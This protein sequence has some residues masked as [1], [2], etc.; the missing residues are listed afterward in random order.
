MA[1]GGATSAT[2][3]ALIALHAAAF[4]LCSCGGGRA[5]RVDR[6]DSAG[7]AIVMNRGPDRPLRWVF[8]RVLVLGGEDEG[9]EAF[10][11]LQR[12][13]VAAGPG[14]EIYVLDVLA[15]RVAAFDSLGGLLWLA[16]RKGGG[17]GEFQAPMSIA[18]SPA[19]EIEVLDLATSLLT[20]LGPEGAYLGSEH[21]A[22]PPYRSR[23]A[24]TAG[25]L[26][27]TIP[28]HDGMLVYVRD[29]DTAELARAPENDAKMVTFRKCGIALRLGRLFSPEL[30]WGASAARVAVN[31]WPDYRV[32]VYVG[33]RLAMSVRRDIVP[34]EPSV[35]LI[36]AKYPRGFSARREGTECRIAAEQLMD[37]LG[38][39]SQVPTIA[40]VLLSPENEL[41]VIRTPT[42]AGETRI[43]L[44]ADDGAYVGTLPAGSPTPVA[45]G[46]RRIITV[47]TD[48]LD[49]PRVVVYR[50]DR[51]TGRS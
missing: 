30:V 13:L 36:R 12:G 46:P 48:S 51:G 10:S 3:G 16:G 38:V 23:L 42:V 45:F 19:G 7:V 11:I 33:P 5:A 4:V 2:R 27:V 25:G 29:A 8:T 35:A 39:A 15:N 22:F 6:A 20:R 18:V 50:V 28:W 17:P 40:D 21:L 37:Q 9:P 49:V 41:W 43:D 32:S 1:R 31:T 14:G 47:E 24:H 44:F 34:S 26:A